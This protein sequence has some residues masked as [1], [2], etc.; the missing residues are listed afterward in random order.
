MALIVAQ[1]L[2]SDTVPSAVNQIHSGLPVSC[3]IGMKV[4]T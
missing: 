1:G 4:L 3:Y 2:G